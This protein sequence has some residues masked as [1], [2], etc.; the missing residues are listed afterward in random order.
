M[1]GDRRC[2]MCRWLDP[3]GG[4]LRDQHG[5]VYCR[6][7]VECGLRQWVAYKAEQARRRL[8]SSNCGGTV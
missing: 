6:D 5:N 8:H 2:C 3:P 4:L 7:V 1:I